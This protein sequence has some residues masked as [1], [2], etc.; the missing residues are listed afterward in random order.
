MA[1][2]VPEESSNGK[3]AAS[4]SKKAGEETVSELNCGGNSQLGW[5]RGALFSSS[6]TFS[7][8]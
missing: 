7:R 3:L 8:V 2:F 5:T 4:F 6:R 1:R